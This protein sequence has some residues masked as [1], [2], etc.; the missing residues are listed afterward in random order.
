MNFKI[1]FNT[2][3]H[4]IILRILKYFF[5]SIFLICFFLYNDIFVYVV[6][7]GCIVYLLITI[8][9]V[10]RLKY[11]PSHISIQ[12]DKIEIRYFRN[13]LKKYIYNIYNIELYNEK[14]YIILKEKNHIILKIKDSDISQENKLKLIELFNKLNSIPNQ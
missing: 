7:C 5:G 10:Q 1:D 3:K 14:E 13:Q 8:L 11:Y 2:K 9:Y 4:N 6:I 12:D